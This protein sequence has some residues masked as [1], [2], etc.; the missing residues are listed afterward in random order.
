MIG[1]R[2][3]KLVIK[4]QLGEGGMGI[5]Y[6]AEHED[7]RNQRVVKV[8][9]PQWAS[10]A[11]IVQRFVNEGR[12][13]AAVSHPNVIEI[14]DTG[15]LPDGSRFI[16]MDYLDGGTLGQFCASQG[17]PLSAHLALQILAPIADGLQAVH[18]RG[19]IHR[20]LKPDNIFL[21]Q[22]DPN[23]H[24]P[25]L[26]DFGI[27]KPGDV[28]DVSVTRTGMM[29]G[30]PAYMAPEQMRDLKLVDQ[31]SDVYAL[32]V[33][34]YQMITGGWHPYD[35]ERTKGE[36]L[37]LSAPEIYHLQ[38]TRPAI[39]PQRRFPGVSEGWSR[40]IMAAIYPDPIRRPQT[41]RAF[42]LLLAEATHGDG[43][44]P[45]GLEIV[46]TYASKLLN[47]G[48]MLETVRS[49]KPSMTG[50]G[51]KLRYQLGERLG[52]GGMAE[53]F[54]GTTVGAEGFSREVA[55]KRVAPGMSVI[56]KFASMFIQ[57]ANLAAELQHPNIVAV[58]DFD[59][60][61]EGRLFLVM[62]YVDGRDLACLMRTGALP[63]SV[64]NFIM[65]EVLRGLGY[66]HDPPKTNLR[67]LVHRDVSPHNVL[68]AFSGA[69]KVSDFGIA[70]AREATEATASSTIKGK[71]A[72]MSPEQANG[73]SLD[74][75]SDLFAVGI[76]LWEMLTTQAL[77]DLRTTEATLSQLFFRP[78]PAPRT[79]RPD[80]PVDL[81]AI[82]M[83]LLERERSARYAK[84]EDVIE[85]LARCV[86]APRNGRS[87]L[88]RLLAERFPGE[89]VARPSSAPAQAPILGELV[90][91][92]ESTN[93]PATAPS[94]PRPGDPPGPVPVMPT[95]VMPAHI[96]PAPFATP[97]SD[98]AWQRARSTL[99][100]ASGQSIAKRPPR[101]KGLWAVGAVLVVA[102]VATSIAIVATRDDT[103]VTASAPSLAAGEPPA[104]PKPLRPPT[105]P[106]LTVTSDPT[107]ASIR[108]DQQERGKTPLEIPVASNSRLVIEAVLPGFE[109][110]TQVITIDRDANT[111]S[112]KLV[113]TLSTPPV[114][115]EKDPNHASKKRPSAKPRR[116]PAAEP[117]TR[118][119]AP[120]DSA[121]KPPDVAKP[122]RKP[123]NPDDV[124]G[125]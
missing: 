16:V 70:K 87:E 97:P 76:M 110:V 64:V 41:S 58:I 43:Y 7:L 37:G 98:G 107:G 45:S 80:V 17:G 114:S 32:G 11:L 50:S 112:F 47:I 61:P 81:E 44:Q 77:F 86:H 95:P 31:R 84:A 28:R 91:D 40:A 116:T 48:N 24:H 10:N 39:D 74:G 12:V 85:D 23:P 14:H 125:E 67:G 57:E 34:A 115:R 35:G 22:R 25:V 99:G 75:R 96:A 56:P 21:V 38:M 124:V 79:I 88:V 62:E 102:V 93:S 9:L 122:P 4:R 92:R 15:E 83:R 103:P 63:F 20:D 33:I 72:Y 52:V 6:L 66:A 100:S 42:A 19:I 120:T 108:I 53:V 51:S 113:S 65:S 89:C 36:C 118:P 1:T 73:E 123:L 69:I 8:L 5:V 27:A 94:V 78:I 2:I 26:L 104:S 55:I 121:P 3:G 18:D 105:M 90:S 119:A 111:A 59:R 106:T 30:T 109:P 49:A 82:A 46:Q 29:A 54:R 101:G 13:A 71:V 117:P 60:D 68:L